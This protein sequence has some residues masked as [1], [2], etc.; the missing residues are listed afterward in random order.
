MFVP[1]VC[2]PVKL[3]E[4]SNLGQAKALC[5]AQGSFFLFSSSGYDVAVVVQIHIQSDL[6]GD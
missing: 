4:R 2:V 5:N 1:G 3:P 6:V